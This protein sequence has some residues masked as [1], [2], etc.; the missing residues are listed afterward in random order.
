MSDNIYYLSNAIFVIKHK[1]KRFIRWLFN[2]FMNDKKIFK[3]INS[4]LDGFKITYS[5][6][7]INNLLNN[8][9]FNTKDVIM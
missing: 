4:I 8:I 9:Y 6:I 1:N 3:D 5:K 2:Y 7:T